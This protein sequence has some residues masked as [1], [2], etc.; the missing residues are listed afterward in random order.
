MQN[1]TIFNTILKNRN[2][3]Y[4]HVLEISSSYEIEIA[5]ESIWYEFQDIATIDELKDFFNTIQLYYY[6]EEEDTE[7]EDTE[8]EDSREEEVY[9]F[10]F[11]EFI[12]NNLI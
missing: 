2:N 7:E 6:S 5:I 3:H 8:E 10:N 12:N 11:D 4:C 9:D 1:N